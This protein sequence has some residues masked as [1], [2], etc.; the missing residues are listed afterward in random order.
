[1]L[2]YITVYST[3]EPAAFRPFSMTID[4]PEDL[5]ETPQ[6]P[7]R[8]IGSH[9]TAQTSE[10]EYIETFLETV[11]DAEFKKNADWDFA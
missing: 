4:I 11:L 5:P 9:A 1:M 2:S 3:K 8:T 7:K 10:E 6:E